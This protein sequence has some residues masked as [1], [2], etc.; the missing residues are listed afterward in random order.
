MSQLEDG[1]AEEQT[2]YR[3][4]TFDRPTFEKRRDYSV[5]F[6]RV[7]ER[8]QNEILDEAALLGVSRAAGFRNHLVGISVTDLDAEKRLQREFACEFTRCHEGLCL[9]QRALALD[10]ECV[11]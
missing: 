9:R 6:R 11:G 4:Q 2:I 1:H 5:A 3:R 10:H 7:I 8:S